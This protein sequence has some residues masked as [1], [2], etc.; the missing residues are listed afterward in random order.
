MFNQCSPRNPEQTT[1]S[2]LPTYSLCK[3]FSSSVSVPSKHFRFFFLQRAR[4]SVGSELN[5]NPMVWFHES[6]P[7]ATASKLQH[8]CFANSGN[9]VLDQPQAGCAHAST[10]C[11]PKLAWSQSTTAESILPSI[12]VAEL[13]SSIPRSLKKCRRVRFQVPAKP[14][15]PRC[16]RREICSVR[17]CW[18]Q[19]KETSVNLKDRPWMR[20]ALLHLQSGLPGRCCERKGEQQPAGELH[21]LRCLR[22]SLQLWTAS[23]GSQP[24]SPDTIPPESSQ[25]LFPVPIPLR[26]HPLP[27]VAKRTAPSP[28]GDALPPAPPLHLLKPIAATGYPR[29]MIR[30]CHPNGGLWH[31]RSGSLLWGFF[32]FLT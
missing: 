6:E 3:L 13:H 5:R 4:S 1:L 8:F 9:Q 11:R 20:R 25:N 23:H 24:A 27:P 17:R 15:Q 22:Q 16:R 2:S 19:R 26:P 32:F 7:W 14:S 12:M 28:P 31:E 29:L 30:P 10:P 21:R 18:S